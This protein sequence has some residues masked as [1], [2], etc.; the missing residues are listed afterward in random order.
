MNEWI[1]WTYIFLNLKYIQY[2]DQM[3]MCVCSTGS[4]Y[5]HV[6]LTKEPS[7]VCHKNFLSR[8]ITNNS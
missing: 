4:K 5:T 8:L 1:S 2:L 6:N 7:Y 3:S